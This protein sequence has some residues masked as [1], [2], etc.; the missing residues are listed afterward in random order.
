MVSIS[1]ICSTEKEIEEY[2]KTVKL[3]EEKKGKISL[4]Y[5][6]KEK[7]ENDIKNNNIILKSDIQ[8]ISYDKPNVQRSNKIVS[9]QERALDKAVELLEERIED[10]QI[11]IM[12]LETEIMDLE[13]KSYSLGHVIDKLRKEEKEILMLIYINKLSFE[14][15]GYILK[16]SKA[17]VSR[18]KENTIK[19]IAAWKEWC[20][21]KI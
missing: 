19:E 8:G 6:Q 11:K 13:S 2:F 16:L 18:K 17:T 3:I 5:K 1:Q 9:L 15:V 20:K 7:V 21:Q 12:D 14:D 4:L 10:I